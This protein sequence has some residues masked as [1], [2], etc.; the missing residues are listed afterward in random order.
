MEKVFHLHPPSI[1][2]VAIG[3][4]QPL[5]PPSMKHSKVFLSLYL[6]ILV[7]WKMFSSIEGTFCHSHVNLLPF[8]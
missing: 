7:A 4:T 8:K 2:L 6:K 5:S 1:L 3:F